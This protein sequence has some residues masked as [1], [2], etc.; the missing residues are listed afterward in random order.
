M[1]RFGVTSAKL[2][3]ALTYLDSGATIDYQ[4]YVEF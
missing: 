2:R 1:A 4:G 3:L